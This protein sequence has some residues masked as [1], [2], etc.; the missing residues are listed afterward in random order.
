[1]RTHSKWH[2]VALVF[3]LAG[4]ALVLLLLG[5]SRATSASEPAAERAVASEGGKAAF[6]TTHLSAGL[7]ETFCLVYT[8]TVNP[9]VT[10]GGIRVID[11][12]F[13]GTGWTM[14]NGD[15]QT[16]DPHAPQYLTVTT[17]GS[18]GLVISRWQAGSPQYQ[19]YTTVEVLAGGLAVGDEV[20]LCY[21]NWR[22][23]HKA[24]QAIE[25]RTLTDADGDAIFAPISTLPQLAIDPSPTPTLMVATGPT[26][27]EKGKPV[28]LTVRVLDEYSNPCKDFVDTLTFT[29]TDSA[30]SLPP[31]NAP[32]PPS[33]G[34]REFV[35][36]LNTLGIQYVYV[37]ADTEPFHINSSPFVVVESLDDYEQVYWG[38]LH[39]HHGHIYTD[40]QT[41][42][43][44]DECMEYARDVTDLDFACESHKTSSYYNVEAVHAELDVSV[45]QYSEPGR[46]VPIRGYEWMGD[47]GS[48]GHHNAYFSGLTTGPLY[49][50]DDPASDTLDE[51]WW[52]LETT[53]PPGEEALF[54]PHA[55]LPPNQGSGANWHNFY[56]T[57][58][59]QRYRPL[60][61]IYSHWG[62]SE[63]GPSSAREALIYGNRVG[64]YGSSDTHFAYPGNP[65][66]EAWG[67][68]G[69]DY[70]AGLAAVRAATLTRPA[71]WQGLTQRHTYATEG[72]RVFLDFSVNDHPM[73]SEIS[74]TVAPRIAV[75]VAGTAPLS[76]VIVFKGSYVTGTAHVGPVDKYYTV[77]HSTTPGGMWTT[78]EITDS[79]FDAST[80][81][82]VRVLQTDG[83]RAWGSPVWVDYGEPVDLWG[84]CGNGVLDPGETLVNCPVD[85][86]IA[87]RSRLEAID[88][89]PTVVVSGTDIPMVGLHV[90]NA[91]NITGYVPYTSSLWVPYMQGLVDR[92]Y[93]SG[94]SYLGFSGMGLGAY[95][96]PAYP[97]AF[98]LTVESN[99]DLDKMDDLFDYAAQ[100]GVY[101]LPTINASKVLTWWVELPSTHGDMVHLDSNGK[102]WQSTA[103]FN[104]PEYW[105]TADPILIAIIQR[106]RDHPALLGW[107][108]RVGEGENN[109]PPPYVMDPF[110]PPTTWCDYSPYAHERF[111]AWLRDRYDNDIDLLRA[112]WVSPTVYFTS[113]MIPKPM[114]AITL[115]TQAEV[116]YY[117]NASADARPEF[118]DW[119][120][121][122]LDEK[123]AETE[124]FVN[125]F[126][127]NDPNHIILNAASVPHA[128]SSPRT[129]RQDGERAYRAPVPDV[130][131]YHPRIAHEDDEPVFNTSRATI[132]HSDQYAVQSGKFTIWANEETS[133][134]G[135]GYD[136]D[137]I[138]RLA[139]FDIMHAALGQ[140]DGWT[141]GNDDDPDNMMPTWSITERVEMRRLAPIHSA[142]DLRVPQPKVAVL[143]DDF[144]DGFNY[145]L[146]G[147]LAAEYSRDTDRRS[148]MQ[149]LFEH[150][151]SY[152]LLTA[153]D[154]ISY[155][156]RLQ[157]YD[158]VLVMNLSRLTTTVAH[159]LD[160]YRDA[161][162]G[163]FVAGVTGRMDDYGRPNTETLEILLDVSVTGWIAQKAQIYEWEFDTVDPLAGPLYTTVVT[164]NVY[165][166]PV[167]PTGHFTEVAHLN[168]TLSAPVVG[169][170][171]KTVFWFPRLT[172]GDDA[173]QIQFQKNLWAFFGVQKDGIAAGSVEVTGGNYRSVFAPTAGTVDVALDD[174]IST[175]GALVWDWNGMRFIDNVPADPSP[176]LTFD[177][178]PNTGYFLGLT[179]L[180]NKVQFVALSG[181]F[182]GPTLDGVTGHKYSVGVYRAKP[183]QPVTAVFYLGDWSAKGVS[184]SGGVLTEAGPDSSGEA[185]VATVSPLDERLTITLEYEDG[186]KKVYLPLALRGY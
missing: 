5:T 81:Y 50:P 8:T 98:T 108:V 62:S 38:D 54:M 184:V 99:W 41:L 144:N 26:Y 82:Y 145:P 151:L 31:A 89:T 117:I 137:N 25:W 176:R 174:S 18:A 156:E 83:K 160:Q 182:L 103:S 93:S 139:S 75:T 51:M 105:A 84:D 147:N 61:E 79:D 183:G 165:Y 170:Q 132:Y 2:L 128:D 23:P 37:N 127:A 113:A 58:L 4:A 179:P 22:T 153:Q 126:H 57:S 134:V 135:A 100:R 10:G 186:D 96:G 159:E 35:V 76:E 33:I 63:S 12:D 110:N 77:L 143:A 122:R 173:D 150:G 90:Y 104:N 56:N 107:D 68:R 91:S 152:D 155:P 13:H 171:G 158:A 20:T 88:G 3:G 55:L 42:R 166:I 53:T 17:S 116:L 181:G 40:A 36:T 1:M 32:F 146:S 130:L 164:D 175:T 16:T 46:F 49:D 48:Q 95:Q 19:S 141:T 94:L 29:S 59:N 15:V 70:V 47:S 136:V 85:A 133:E 154:V 27:V 115:T 121:F 72:E 34:V 97:T 125:L 168:G 7:T 71:L 142:P 149:N 101:L 6:T 118:R 66:T 119:I 52:L 180:T 43:R 30:A 167:L 109:Y 111:Q 102:R 67:D 92:V 178:Q 69:Q 64:F 86:Q 39:G 65:Q 140:G 120:E 74:A 131:I 163:L 177:I 124:H 169:Y 157:R 106:Y 28:T 161:G 129:G 44:V 162:G 80:F 114:D 24:Y 45:V 87:Q 73:G 11:P 60:V 172:L 123:Y 185:Y 148:F 9:I 138:W 14:W 78:F 21:V 112:A